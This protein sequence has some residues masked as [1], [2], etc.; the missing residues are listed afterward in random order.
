MFAGDVGEEP[1]V[2]NAEYAI[3][4]PE[5]E[6]EELSSDQEVF[7]AGTVEFLSCAIVS[8]ECFSGL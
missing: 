2:D 3:E 8:D 5:K 7:E 1:P 4:V 6:E